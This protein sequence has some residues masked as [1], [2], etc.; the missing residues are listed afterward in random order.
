MNT[1]QGCEIRVFHCIYVEMKD[2]FYV[3]EKLAL[4]N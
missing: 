3:G 1:E 2:V 4:I